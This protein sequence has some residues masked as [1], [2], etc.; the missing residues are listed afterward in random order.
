MSKAYRPA[1][2]AA[3]ATVAAVV[4]VVPAVAPAVAQDKVI[5]KVDGQPLTEGEL[6]A[7]MQSMTQQTG[8]LPEAAKRKLAFDRLVDMK[9]LASQAAKDGLDKSD[10]FKRRMDQIRQQLLINEYVKVKVDATVTD[11]MVKAR[12]EKEIAGF[13]PPEELRARHI[14]VKTKDEADAVIKELDA[15]GDFAKLA[16]DK[17]QDPGSA[18]EGGDLGYFAAGDMVAPFEEAAGKLEIG[19]Y[20]K[21][22]VETQFGFHVIK[23]E[24]KRKQ[25]APAFDDVKDQIRQSVVGEMFTAQLAAIKKDVKID[26]EDPTLQQK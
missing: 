22:P 1:L 25:K 24:D 17:S 10:D 13:T 6:G 20:T 7:V 21:A 18:K 16:A 5:A 3:L 26:V 4:A 11:A 2:L 15:G 23:L 9:V 14:L 19:A 12:Y 8:Q